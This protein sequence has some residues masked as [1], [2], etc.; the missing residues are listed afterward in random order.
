M[1]SAQAA[2]SDSKTGELPSPHGPTRAFGARA[3]FRSLKTLAAASI[4]LSLRTS[5]APPRRPG[6]EC[7][8]LVP[9]CAGVVGPAGSRSGGRRGMGR[10][11]ASVIHVA[12]YG[13]AYSGNFIASLRALQQP[14][15][16][17]GLSLAFVFSDCAAGRPW[18]A[19]LRRDG[20]ST[21]VLC[22]RDSLTS[23]TRALAEITV[24][25]RAT[26]IHTHF[27]MYDVPAASR[28]A[29][30]STSRLR[31]SVP[32]PRAAPPWCSSSSGRCSYVHS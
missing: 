14:C 31:R 9:H 5:L 22:G 21:Y 11:P 16:A 25:E 13:A 4:C 1:V 8:P 20:L 18:L 28:S 7:L 27:G 15:S 26:L 6:T 30:A 24:R 23:R 32:C 3:P 10:R 2:S 12:A 17:M 19:E 29:R